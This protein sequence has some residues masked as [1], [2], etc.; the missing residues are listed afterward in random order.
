MRGGTKE[1]RTVGR[2][3]LAR[4]DSSP[5]HE[6]D[7]WKEGESRPDVTSSTP[8][9]SR[10]KEKSEKRRSISSVSPSKQTKEKQKQW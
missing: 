2:G 7:S 8:P 3:G 10:E 9:R 1:K 6:E 5:P 4:D